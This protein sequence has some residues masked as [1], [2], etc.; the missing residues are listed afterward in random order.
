MVQDAVEIADVEAISGTELS[1][2]CLVGGK[3]V[4]VPLALILPGSEVHR[5]GDHGKLAIPKTLAITLGL[6]C[7][8]GVAA[9]KVRLFLVSCR[10]CQR[11]VIMVAR[12]GH[13][14]LVQL[15]HHL[16]GCARYEALGA[17]PGVMATLGHF[18]VMP[19]SLE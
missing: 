11:P 4:G 1:L 18:R 13:P 7:D 10:H 3:R 17:A 14:E 6:A 12:I 16:R 5:P 19:T 2:F 9:N 15:Q 8:S